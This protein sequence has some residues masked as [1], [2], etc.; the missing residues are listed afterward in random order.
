MI[1]SSVDHHRLLR[2]RFD[3]AQD[4]RLFDKGSQE[5]RLRHFMLSGWLSLLTYNGFLAVDWLVSSDVF[6]LGVVMRLFVFTSFGA[7]TMLLA[8]AYR[9]VILAL[10]S[11]VTEAVILLTGLIAALSVAAVLT[12]PGM[13][14]SQ[15]TVYYHGG[16]VPIIIYGTVV[17]RLRFRM[18]GCFVGGVLL[19]HWLCMA[20]GYRDATS[21]VVPMLLFVSSMAGYT[22]IINYRLEYE[23]RQQFLRQQRA[24]VLREQ[25]DLSRVELEKAASR[26]PLTGVANRRAF[27]QA[28]Q[29]AWSDAIQARTSVALL[30]VDVDHFKAYNDFYGH[31]AG[32]ECLRLVAQAL[33]DVAQAEGGLVARWGGEEFALLLPGR[34]LDGALRVANQARAAIQGARLR[35][36]RSGT[37]ATV[38]ASLGVSAAMPTPG[39]HWAHL[40]AQ[41]DAALYEA[42]RTGRNRVAAPPRAQAM[43]G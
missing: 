19:I 36:E 39:A 6:A 35:H 40:L 31:P 26:D 17:Q 23:D 43:A 11:L 22:L 30:L 15:W 20:I 41:A 38:T 33:G 10:P 27:D 37:A 18:A 5:A 13:G 42:K 34:A 24:R 1:P 2:L 21:P 12:S 8:A 16:F 3:S 32:D 28:M 14:H 9:H 25:L 7:A 29:R 4:E